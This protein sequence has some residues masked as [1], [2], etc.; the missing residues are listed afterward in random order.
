[1]KLIVY[2]QPVIITKYT[3][4]LCAFMMGSGSPCQNLFCNNNHFNWTL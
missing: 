3:A 1:M 4:S 2:N